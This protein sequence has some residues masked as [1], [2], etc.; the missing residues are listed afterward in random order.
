MGHR[1]PT[2]ALPRAG[3]LRL[4][5]GGTGHAQRRSRGQ[6]CFAGAGTRL[7]AGA[8]L[9]LELR[10]PELDLPGVSHPPL[11]LRAR[12]PKPARE[13]R[14]AASQ[15]PGRP[16]LVRSPEPRAGKSPGRS[17]AGWDAFRAVALPGH[18]PG[19]TVGLG[20]G[21]LAGEAEARPGQGRCGCSSRS[22]WDSWLSVRRRR[23][24]HGPCCGVGGVGW[25]P[26][27]CFQVGGR[28]E[29]GLY[30]QAQLPSARRKGLGSLVLPKPGTR[31]AG[32]VGQAAERSSFLP[33][34]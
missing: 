17:L 11:V 6:D 7:R 23:P 28:Q 33:Q 25:R 2:S 21:E 18:E 16:K 29:R 12:Q 24:G 3:A 31:R 27:R 15:H 20:H 5:H 13:L 14:A 4:A 34:S 10:L 22:D 1:P 9:Q 26:D 19:C 30:A 32:R 8:R